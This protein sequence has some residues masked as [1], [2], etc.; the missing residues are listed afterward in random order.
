MKYDNCGTLRDAIE[1]WSPEAGIDSQGNACTTW[2][3]TAAIHAEARDLSGRE[4]FAAAAHQLEN[5]M[6]FKIRWRQGLTTGTRLRYA[7]AWYEILQ[8]NHLGNRRGGW[9]LLRAR[10]IQGEG[11]TYG[12]L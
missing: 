3:L 12:T 11:V 8:I 1:L 9:M 2:Q 6:Q 7:G 5:V 10:L 4:F